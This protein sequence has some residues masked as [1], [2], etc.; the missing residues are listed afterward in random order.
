MF[1]FLPVG[2]FG[3]EA[4][5]VPPDTE[6][7]RLTRPPTTAGT[8]E[9]NHNSSGGGGGGVVYGSVSSSTGITSPTN[10]LSVPPVV[11]Q[12]P[13]PG[14]DNDEL[15]AGA[16]S[17]DSIP[18]EYQSNDRGDNDDDEEEEDDDPLLDGPD[19]DAMDDALT[20]LT[21][22]LRCLF[23]VVT[24]PIVPLGSIA[25][26]GLL[27]L[28]YASFVMD[29]NNTCSHPIHWY[30]AVSLGVLIYMPFH[31]QIRSYFFQYDRERDGPSRP[32]GVRRYDQCFNTIALLYVY[33]GITFVQTCRDDLIL[34]D[35]TSPGDAANI[36][37]SS[38]NNSCAATCPNTFASLRV[39]VACLELFV[40][41]LVIPLLFLPCL[42]LY[43]VR[44]T[45]QDAEALALLRDRLREEE[46]MRRNGGITADEILANFETVQLMVDPRIIDHRVI[47]VPRPRK[48]PDTSDA[49]ISSPAY[50]DFSKAKDCDMKECCICMK[51]FK[52]HVPS[53]I[54]AGATTAAAADEDAC[55]DNIVRTSK[56]CE[57]LFH[58]RCIASWVGGRWE[59]R[60]NPEQRPARHTTCPLCRRDFRPNH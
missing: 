7:S 17:D 45:M 27:W 32:I 60:N 43:F 54:E 39:Y 30:A 14:R 53:D 44:R 8:D 48:A 36:D 19:P 16:I 47:V 29:R 49:E 28:L 21:R 59:G 58:E 38:L 22:R 6:S 4:V 1:S 31:T 13:D 3:R 56:T 55:D 52:V 35:G 25:I 33:A 34:P 26:L 24:W 50:I 23:S 12:D 9:D 51:S 11:R 57:H 37:V 20:S 40:L 42:Y 2:L 46:A 10:V 15:S 41:S 18:P 5:P